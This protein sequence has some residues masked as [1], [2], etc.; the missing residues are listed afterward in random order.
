MSS[1]GAG[2]SCFPLIFSDYIAMAVHMGCGMADLGTERMAGI[3]TSEGSCPVLNRCRLPS[4]PTT[5][6]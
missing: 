4:D 1:I 5:I 2:S 6:H 3:R